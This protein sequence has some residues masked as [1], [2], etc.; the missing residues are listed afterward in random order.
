MEGFR[1]HGYSE[2]ASEEVLQC[3]NKNPKD[4]CGVPISRTALLIFIVG[5]LIFC[6]RVQAVE[7]TL[8]YSNDMRGIIDPC[9]T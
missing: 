7:L 8:L 3:R 5:F 4:K 2:P 1:Y 9:P 6:Q